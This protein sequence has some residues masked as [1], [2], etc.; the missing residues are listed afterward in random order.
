MFDWIVVFNKIG[1]LITILK[2]FLL[3]KISY[4]LRFLM[5]IVKH[6]PALIWSFLSKDTEGS[7]TGEYELT[8]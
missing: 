6:I 7:T 3:P 5:C 2:L 8:S 4:S 1:T